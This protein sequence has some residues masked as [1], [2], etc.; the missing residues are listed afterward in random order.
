VL[1]TVGASAKEVVMINDR[2]LIIGAIIVVAVIAAY[3][4]VTRY[5]ATSSQANPATTTEPKK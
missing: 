3:F 1:R 4:V 2:N 5:N